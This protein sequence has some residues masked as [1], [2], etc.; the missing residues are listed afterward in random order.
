MLE[1]NGAL[2]HSFMNTVVLEDFQK[3]GFPDLA[4]AR[5]A[6]TEE[7]LLETPI[8]H[9]GQSIGLLTGGYEQAPI[10]THK[11]Y[12]TQLEGEY[13]GGD[14]AGIPR[15]ILYPDFFKDR[16]LRGTPLA[17]DSYAWI[18]G[19]GKVA[20]PMNQEWLD[21]VMSYKQSGL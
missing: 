16:R 19:Q 10:K 20:Q 1:N 11:T 6:I 9:G 15:E 4:P 2:R 17:G 8:G 3:R 18:R 13:I 7:K 5:L 12:N 21:R 14:P